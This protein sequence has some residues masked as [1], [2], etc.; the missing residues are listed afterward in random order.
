MGSEMCIRDSSWEVFLVEY[1]FANQNSNDELVFEDGVSSRIINMDET[2][3]SLDENNGNRGG[4]PVSRQSD[5]KV[6]F[7][8]DYEKWHLCKWGAN[9]PHFQFQTAA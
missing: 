4:R 2:C 9:S 6:S 8:N 5:I 1:G 7:D 3:I